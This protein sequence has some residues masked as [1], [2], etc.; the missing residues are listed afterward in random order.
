MSK[1]GPVQWESTASVLKSEH[2]KIS[3]PEDDRK[4]KPL[5]PKDH[6]QM[7][8]AKALLLYS[9]CLVRAHFQLASGA[10]AGPRY[11][12]MQS[13]LDVL[14]ITRSQSADRVALCDHPFFWVKFMAPPNYKL[15]VGGVVPVIERF[16]DTRVA[17][18]VIG[19]GLTGGEAA[20][21]P[22]AIQDQ[23]PT[24]M[25]AYAIPGHPDQSSCLPGGGGGG[26]CTCHFLEDRVSLFSYKSV[27][28]EAAPFATHFD[29]PTKRCHYH[30]EWAGSDM[31]VVQD[32]HVELAAP[33]LHYI[34][35]W[36][37]GDQVLG[38]P[39]AT[40]K[41]GA[42]FG[43]VGQSE[44]FHGA[45][46][47]ISDCVQTHN[48]FNENDC[49]AGGSEADAGGGEA[50]VGGCPLEGC[51][52]SPGCSEIPACPSLA[53]RL[54]DAV[55]SQFPPCAGFY[56]AAFPNAYSCLAG[57]SSDTAVCNT[58][59]GNQGSCGTAD[60]NCESPDSLCGATCAR[61]A[62]GMGQGEDG[63]QGPDGPACDIDPLCE[64]ERR[65]KRSLLFA[66]MVDDTT[67]ADTEVCPA[68]C[69]GEYPMAVAD[70]DEHSDVG[71]APVHSHGRPIQCT[72]NFATDQVPCAFEYAGVFEVPAA[73]TYELRFEKEGGVYGAGDASIKLAM[74]GPFDGVLTEDALI[75]GHE[76]LGGCNIEV[77]EEFDWTQMILGADGEDAGQ[78]AT[79]G[80]PAGDVS[81][82]IPGCPGTSPRCSAEGVP[83][84]CKGGRRQLLHSG[85]PLFRGRSMGGHTTGMPEICWDESITLPECT[86]GEM[87]AG[88]QACNL[89]FSMG[90]EYS[91]LYVELP[92]PGAYAF[93]AEHD[94]N[95]FKVDSLHTP[96]GSVP[97]AISVVGGGHAHAPH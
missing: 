58:L 28:A 25:G 9:T 62:C 69:S 48:Q 2:K 26:G 72:P 80:P 10:T 75:A 93:F 8:L 30:E 54:A 91:S 88:A 41:F 77:V 12:D 17:A 85:R 5:S 81:C 87:P 1:W 14:D 59:C 27:G 13:A 61:A 84:A 45:M 71:S 47:P 21:L 24:G 51:P 7:L 44:A 33:G 53:R 63:V 36:A 38:P 57:S 97:V 73:G 70:G 82:P 6:M 22:Q 39:T 86:G 3:N 89:M 74:S 78:P 79:G 83:E 19:P 23:V 66:S 60:V 64:S 67:E 20:K 90:A 15:M 16:W 37:P 55:S 31:W 35:F 43:D 34:V 56:G 65:R 76:K 11:A 46:A 4:S 50:D 94:M 40:A 95:E 29:W 42:V 52:W 96:N 49:H 92:S 18:A 68:T 32:K